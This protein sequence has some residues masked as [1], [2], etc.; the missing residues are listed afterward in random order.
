M[1]YN[2]DLIL[3]ITIHISHKGM[4]ILSLAISFYII[5]F[6]IKIFIFLVK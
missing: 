1:I 2:K 3:R 4:I 6:S 5:Q